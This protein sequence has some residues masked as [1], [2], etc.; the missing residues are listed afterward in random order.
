MEIIQARKVSPSNCGCLCRSRLLLCSWL[1]FEVLNAWKSSNQNYND[2]H[3][4]F[5]HI[6]KHYWS[7]QEQTSVPTLVLTL[8]FSS[9]ALVICRNSGLHQNG[10]S[11]L[12]LTF[13][14]GLSICICQISACH[15]AYPSSTS[16]PE[17]SVGHDARNTTR[18]CERPSCRD[19][20]VW[21]C[22]CK[23][24]SEPATWLKIV[25][26]SLQTLFRLK[27]QRSASCWPLKAS[28]SLSSACS[29]PRFRRDLRIG[30]FWKG[31]PKLKPPLT[32]D[33]LSFVVKHHQT[34][35]GAESTVF[36]TYP[37]VRTLLMCQLQGESIH[38]IIRF[39]CL[40]CE[41]NHENPKSKTTTQCVA[42]QN[43]QDVALV[44]VV[45]TNLLT[46]SASSTTVYIDM[47]FPNTSSNIHQSN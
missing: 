6:N 18:E 47:L 32:R 16:P 23:A 3:G 40:P 46:L 17:L 37:S 27:I 41:K 11:L 19:S 28:S 35:S 7:Y 14:G 13:R 9:F 38:R 25:D 5:E 31:F 8:S 10:S 34:I 30:R 36:F 39:F 21:S 20:A 29:L 26:G 44:F 1:C 2:S 33:F 22:A 15:Q 4:N 43:Q 42:P 45:E 12:C 24:A